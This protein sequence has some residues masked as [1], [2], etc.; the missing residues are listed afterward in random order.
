[1]F[2]ILKRL[3]GRKRVPEPDPF[4]DRAL[5]AVDP[6]FASELGIPTETEDAARASREIVRRLLESEQAQLRGRR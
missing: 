6:K 2:R 3:F 5:R 1:M 4:A